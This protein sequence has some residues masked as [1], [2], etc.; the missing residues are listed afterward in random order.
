MNSFYKFLPFAV[1]I[2]LECFDVGLTTL[3]KAAFSTGLNHFTF[4]VYSNALASI[5]LCPVAF[6]ADRGK[7]PPLTWP[8]LGRFFVLALCGFTI[9]QNCVFTGVSY[10]SPTLATAMANLIPA[11][12]FVLSIIFRLEKV[13]IRSSSSQA[14]ILGTFISVGGAMII[15]FYKGTV[16]KNFWFLNHDSEE[17]YHTSEK[18]TTLKDWIIGSLFLA[19]ASIS[20][21][22]W[23]IM[24]VATLKRYPA[25]LSIT[26]FTTTFAAMQSAILTSVAEHNLAVW[27]LNWAIDVISILYSAIIGTGLTYTMQTWCNRK[28]GPLFVAMF[29]PIGIVIAAIASAIF[30]GDKLHIGSVLGAFF[31]V[32]GF[33]AVIWAQSKDANTTE[34]QSSIDS[35][36]CQFNPIDGDLI[37]DDPIETRQLLLANKA[38]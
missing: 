3:S 7:R 10:A 11:F 20:W 13:N 9:M 5:L 29:K 30:L 25:E 28:K 16:I 31:I 6:L 2:S 36:D 27:S 1:M 18:T 22:T 21:S 37:D 35:G 12:T 8:M 32:S 19:G 14:K 38:P 24:Q 33:Y 26:F 34:K 4:V 15:T 23:N 17:N